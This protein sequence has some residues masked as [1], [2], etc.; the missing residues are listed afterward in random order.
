[1]AKTFNCKIFD[2]ISK[3]FGLAKVKYYF[4]V[5]LNEEE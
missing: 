4:A 2:V 1:M 5:D 3:R